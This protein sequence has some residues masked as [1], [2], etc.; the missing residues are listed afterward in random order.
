MWTFIVKMYDSGS[1]A[2]ACGA[3]DLMGSKAQQS[4][5]KTDPFFLSLLH[6]PSVNWMSLSQCCIDA[7][8]EDL[9]V[10]LHMLVTKQS[11]IVDMFE[12]NI[13]LSGCLMV[14]S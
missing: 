7:A 8:C 3:T 4:L 6:H 9:H 10:N 1:R 14:L 13:M 2:R 12:G 11:H 5:K